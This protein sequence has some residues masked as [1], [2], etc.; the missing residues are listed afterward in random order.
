[1]RQADRMVFQRLLQRAANRL[2]SQ[3][4]QNQSHFQVELVCSEPVAVAAYVL[5][6]T[7][8]SAAATYR[9]RPVFWAIPTVRPVCDCWWWIGGG[10]TDIAYVDI[11]WKT[12]DDD[13]SVD[14]TFRLLES[15]RFTRAGDRLSHI[16]ATAILTLS[17][18]NT[19]SPNR[20]ISAESSNP[21]FTRAYK[22]LIVSKISEL[23]EDAKIALAGPRALGVWKRT[24]STI[25]CVASSRC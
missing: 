10:S 1:M 16:I 7:F 18:R 6:E 20:W 21:G 14:V 24:A 9:W 22:R 2:F 4:E 3:D 23:A 8:I 25:S 13:E 12:R 17:G 5:W 19:P 11:H 15:M